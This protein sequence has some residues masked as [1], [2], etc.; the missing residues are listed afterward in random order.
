MNV[1]YNIFLHTLVYTL[2]NDFTF[3]VIYIY[4]YIYIRCKDYMTKL[5]PT[6][7]SGNSNNSPSNNDM[8]M[9]IDYDH[10]IDGQHE[11]DGVRLLPSTPAH[12]LQRISSLM[13]TRHDC[14]VATFSKSGCE[15]SNLVN[16]YIK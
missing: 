8:T 9:G 1:I 6:T 16:K 2:L 10:L 3:E 11:F 14:L 15:H 13:T 7:Y 12:H 5:I 4:K